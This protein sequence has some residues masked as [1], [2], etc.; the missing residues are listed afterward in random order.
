MSKVDQHKC[1][2]CMTCVHSC[3]Y[4]AP[5]MNIDHK[6][7]IAAAKCMGCGICVSAC[8]RKVIQLQH[9]TDKQVVAK[10]MAVCGV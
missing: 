8:P 10:G 2:S 5:F 4:G 1:I 9:M 7:E 6:A 3:P